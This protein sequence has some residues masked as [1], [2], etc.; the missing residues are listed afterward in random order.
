MHETS[1]CIHIYVCH[2]FMENDFIHLNLNLVVG[3]A[4][5]ITNIRNS[6][7]TINKIIKFFRKSAKRQTILN[8]AVEGINCEEKR[9][10]LKR[11]CITRWVER[12]D[13][14]I[15]FKDFF[16]PI[17]IA[18]IEIEEEGDSK[19]S[20]KASN[21][22]HSM[23]NG[24]FIVA[25]VVIDEIFS[26]IQPLSVALQA[27]DIDLAS[28]LEMANNL[29]ELLKK[30]RETATE[31]FETLFEIAKMLANEVDAEIKLTRIAHK[32]QNRD[33]YRDSVEEY[34]RLSVFIPF[35]DHVIGQLNERFLRHKN[36]LAKIENVLPN[37]IINLN[38]ND[39]NATIDEFIIQWP[40]INT[41]SD[42]V[43]KKEALLWQQ[44]WICSNELPNTFIE[45]LNMCNKSVFPNMKVIL[46]IC[47]TI[48]VTTATVER[49][50]ST[51]RRLKNYLRNTTSESR[52]NG[53]AAMS[54]QREIEIDIENVIDIFAQKPRK[55]D[56]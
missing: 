9:K 49:S 27:K 56:L 51:L 48:P 1:L 47:A 23:Q 19:A 5:K 28:A 33:N 43:I 39:L 21:L 13:A 10:R 46:K 31:K 52:L 32:Q 37:K 4:C 8:A 50:F 29:S 11:M 14:V 12:L 16:Y 34:Y 24:S 2:E 38:E 15:M 55:I 25:M 18:L 41:T 30:I 40:I 42:N 35:L 22:L 7:G 26:F 3:D 53:L 54:I 36:I 6:I 17:Y 20:Q 44:R 45:A